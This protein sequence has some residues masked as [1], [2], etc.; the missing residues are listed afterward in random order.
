MV[1]ALPHALLQT[2]DGPP[3]SSPAANGTFLMAAVVCLGVGYVFM[4]YPR[5]MFVVRHP[6]T[7]DSADAMTDTGKAVYE[8]GGFASATFGAAA[9]T[10][11]LRAKLAP[12]TLPV[13]AGAV[14][15]SLVGVALTR[16]DT[17]RVQ[18]AG[19]AALVAGLGTALSFGLLAL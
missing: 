8:L 5:R 10:L 3:S 19:V 7:V 1:P 18:D 13:A 2:P 14:V 6:L 16:H 9:A 11:L 12:G 15:V 17:R 4:R